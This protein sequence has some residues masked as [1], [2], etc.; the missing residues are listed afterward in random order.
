[1]SGTFTYNPAAGAALDAGT[2]TLTAIFIPDSTNNYP[3]TNT[4]SLVVTPAPLTVTV[5]N[6][7]RAFGQTNPVL[8]ATVVGL[9]NGDNITAK[10]SCSAGLTSLPGIYPINVVLVDPGQRLGNYLVMT[11]PGVLTVTSGAQVLTHDDSSAY[12]SRQVPGGGTW[13]TG[14]NFGFGFLPWVIRTNGPANQ[15]AFI[16][17]GGSIALVDGSV[18]ALYANG[19]PFTNTAV[20]FRGLSNSL[21][22]GLAF[23][24]E[25]R[26]GY[27]GTNSLNFAGFSLRSG[28]ASDSTADLATGEQMAFFYRG[29]ADTTNPMDDAIIRDGAGENYAPAPGVNFASLQAG[30]AVEFTL[31]SNNTYRLLILDAATSNTIATFDNR[32]LAGSGTIDSLALFDNQTDPLDDVNNGN[33]YFN[34]LEIANP[35]TPVLPAAMVT[36]ADLAVTAG[37]TATFTAAATGTPPLVYQWQFNGRNLSGANGA[38]LTISNVQVNNGGQ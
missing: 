27:I 32:T 37:S 17:A 3:A 21:P 9:Q 6:L 1:V 35:A 19:Q 24:L 11:N 22:V 2:Q 4:V 30:I 36:P 15:G 20:A 7:S 26:S 10:L 28:N 34:N 5:S 29:S 16:G 31:L 38:S 23:K 8:T 14:Q 12:S 25:W 33:Q 18:W 13:M